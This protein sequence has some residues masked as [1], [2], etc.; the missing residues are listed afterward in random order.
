MIKS[1]K[2]YKWYTYEGYSNQWFINSRW[3]TPLRHGDVFGVR[4]STDGYK[5][6]LVL[7]KLGVTKVITINNTEYDTIMRTSRV[8]QKKKPTKKKLTVNVQFEVSFPSYNSI[9]KNRTAQ[10]FI[11]DTIKEAIKSQGHMPLYINT[12]E[13]NSTGPIDKVLVDSGF[14]AK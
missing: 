5:I 8:V 9:E 6:R 3:D 2:T 4:S 12:G 10:R 13:S 11:E 1:S 7:K 14:L